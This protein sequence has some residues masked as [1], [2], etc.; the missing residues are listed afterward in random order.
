MVVAADADAD[1]D[2][3]RGAVDGG[4]S[5]A[6]AGGGRG[7]VKAIDSPPGSAGGGVGSA[8]WSATMGGLNVVADELSRAI[9][10]AAA[11]VSRRAR[12]AITLVETS[13]IAAKM[14]PNIQV[15]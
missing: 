3:D 13:M 10:S 7:A 5:A 9:G 4:S 11:L 1:A 12:W 14:P 8:G 2:A 15:G 6:N